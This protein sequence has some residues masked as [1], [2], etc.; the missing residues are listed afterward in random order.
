[1]TD[2]RTT[3]DPIPSTSPPGAEGST[4]DQ[5]KEV[6]KGAVDRASDVAGQASEQA[7]AVVRDARDHAR[8]VVARSRE[9]VDVEARARSRQAAGGLRSL[10]DQLGALIEGDQ[11]RAGVLGDYARQ[12]REK[13]DQL[14]SRLDDGPTAV[15][16]DVRRFA[17]RQPALFLAAAGAVG[18]IAGRLVRGVR[19]ADD[20]GTPPTGQRSDNGPSGMVVPAS[21]GAATIDGPSTGIPTT[22]PLSGAE[23]LTP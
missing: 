7:K 10:S 21:A 15:L 13:L 22:A 9:H 3:S 5:A 6:A 18:F 19:D 12:G 20:G 1:M 23:G 4:A 17:R 8:E 14:A 2:Q 11:Q 16:D